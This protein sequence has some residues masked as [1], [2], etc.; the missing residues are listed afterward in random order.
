MALNEVLW[1]YFMN[2]LN[3]LYEML[4]DDVRFW[5]TEQLFKFSEQ[6]LKRKN[7]TSKP[8]LNSYAL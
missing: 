4:C 1:I 7:L 5:V 8:I 2:D 6:S 3:E